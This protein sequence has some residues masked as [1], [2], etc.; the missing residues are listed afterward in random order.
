MIV[1]NSVTGRTRNF[2]SVYYVL[3]LMLQGKLYVLPVS[4]K[5]TVNIVPV[6]YVAKQVV[7]LSTHQQ[8]EGLTFHL[9][10][11]SEQLP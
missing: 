10:A 3:K 6:D 7:A 11:P 9:T 2:N 4:S 8:A 5:Q 1:G